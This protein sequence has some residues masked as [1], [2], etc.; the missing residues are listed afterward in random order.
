MKAAEILIKNIEA[1]EALPVERV[2]FETEFIIR[3][4]TKIMN[5]IVQKK[6]TYLN[7]STIF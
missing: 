5:C 7:Q 4:S 3:D 1:P 2:E 6:I